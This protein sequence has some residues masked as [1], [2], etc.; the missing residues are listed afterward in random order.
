MKFRGF[1]M[2]FLMLILPLLAPSS[3]AD[4]T[5]LGNAAPFAVLAGSTITNTDTT[6]I[7]GNVGLSPGT[8][9][10]GTT[11]CPAADCFQLTGVIDA[12]NAVALQA[13]ND[14]TIAY[15]T[16]AGLASTS[17]LSGQN[18]GG[19]TLTPG[20]YKF[21]SSA[22]LTGKLTL[23]AQGDAN[24]FWVFQIGSTLTTASASSVVIINEAKNADNGLFWQV[25]SSAT[26]GTTT[27][28]LG[29]IVALTSITLNTDATDNC[30]RL[31]ARNGAVTLD[32]NV[33]S[34]GCNG[35]HVAKD[36]T[37]E[38]GSNGLSGGLTGGGTAN[39][40]ESGTLLLVGCGMFCIV[41]LRRNAWTLQRFGSTRS[42]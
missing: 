7:N 34:I 41:F 33:I 28:F 14:L 36:V 30:G 31:L 27:D 12:T 39:T 32:D 23:N 26:L 8:S 42:L 16:L 20:V 21:D 40:P 18:L 5:L 29:N 22:Q 10:T 1:T 4:T 11:L 3:H 6:I 13:Q 37:N 2:L 38:S 35:R 19:L 17:D 9:L 24:A 15:T 25:G